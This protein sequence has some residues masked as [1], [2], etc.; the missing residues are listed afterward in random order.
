MVADSAPGSAA[1]AAASPG[2]ASGVRSLSLCALA[3]SRLLYICEAAAEATPPMA[4]PM[5]EPA[6]P[7]LDDRANDVAAARPLAMTVDTEKSPK[8]PFSSVPF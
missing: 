6:R 2:V 4:T 5:I 1:D 3:L 8:R 7:I